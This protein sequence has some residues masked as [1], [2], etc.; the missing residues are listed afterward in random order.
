[1]KKSFLVSMFAGAAMLFNGVAYAEDFEISLQTMYNPAQQQ[2]KDVFEPFAKEVGELS[3]GSLKVN[4]FGVGSLVPALQ[5]ADAVKAGNLDIGQCALTHPKETPYAYLLSMIPDMCD[6]IADTAVFPQIVYDSVPELKKEYDSIGVPLGWIVYV[7]QV[8]CATNGLIKTPADMKGKRILVTA[9]NQSLLVEAWGGTPVMVA[10][11]D[12]Y[13][14]LQRG[15]GEAYMSGSAWCKGS[16]I[17]EVAKYI[18]Q[19]GYPNTN[20]M[21]LAMNKELFDD[22][23]DE[24]RKII[25][26]TG[27]KYFGQIFIDSFVKEND[28]AIQLFKDNGCE[29]YVPTSEE[30]A[31]WQEANKKMVAVANDRL[32]ELGVNDGQQILDKIYKSLDDAG[33]HKN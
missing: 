21:P 23:S 30:R 25:I 27:K 15:M 9:P 29:F 20:V 31:Q 16:K 10:L 6:T 13:I 32:K 18:T 14:G 17:Y 26:D 2:M 3:K 19:V 22:L 24:Q 12:V 11:S 5:E 8:I 33:Y 4:V 1:M 28:L 7:P